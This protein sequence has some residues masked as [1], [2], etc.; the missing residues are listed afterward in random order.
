MSKTIMFQVDHTVAR[1]AAYP[2]IGDQLDLL[3][4]GFSL[5]KADGVELPP[6]IADWVDQIQAVKDKYPKPV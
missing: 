5:A 2:P 6:Y 3:F 1:A 4:K